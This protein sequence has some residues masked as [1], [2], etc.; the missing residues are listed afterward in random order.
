MLPAG[1]RDPA[2]RGVQRGGGGT[3]PERDVV[4]GEPTLGL[5]RQ[6]VL[7]ALAQQEVLGQRRTLVGQVRLGG[8][9]RHGAF[10]AGVAEGAGRGQPGRPAADDDHSGAP[11]SRAF[12]HVEPVVRAVLAAQRM[13]VDAGRQRAVHLPALERILARL[14]GP[15]HC[16][17]HAAGGERPRSRCPGRARAARAPSSRGP[18]S[19][20]S[21]RSCRPASPRA[22][23]HAGRARARGRA[24]AHGRRSTAAGAMSTATSSRH[25][26]ASSAVNT[27]IEQPTSSPRSNCHGAQRPQRMCRTCPARTGWWR[28]PTDP[29]RGRTDRRSSRARGGPPARGSCVQ[30]PAPE[31]DQQWVQPVLVEEQLEVAAGSVQAAAGG[32][33]TRSEPAPPGGWWSVPRRPRRPAAPPTGPWS[34]R[35]DLPRWRRRRARTTRSIVPAAAVIRP[36][37]RARGRR[38]PA[39]VPAWPRL[40]PHGVHQS[41]PAGGGADGVPAEVRLAGD[42]AGS[43]YHR[44]HGR[45]AEYHAVALG[46]AHARRA[47]P[48]VVHLRALGHV[49]IG[50][51]RRPGLSPLTSTNAA[52]TPPAPEQKVLT[53]LTRLHQARRLPSPVP[54]SAPQ[55]PSS[56][57]VVAH[58]RTRARAATRGGLA[59]ALDGV[60]VAV[61]DAGHRAIGA[62]HGADDSPLLTRRRPGRG[63]AGGPEAAKASVGERGQRSSCA[64]LAA[65]PPW[66]PPRSAGESNARC[67]TAPPATRATPRVGPSRPAADSVAPTVWAQSGAPRTRAEPVVHQ[68]H[69]ALPDGRGAGGEHAAACRHAS[70]VF[71]RPSARSSRSRRSASSLVWSVITP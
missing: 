61:Q 2:G 16:Q 39:A 50:Q 27:P 54:G 52:S 51:Q 7:T 21:G 64:A 42:L 70:R 68:H 71:R 29:H 69:A 53:P 6:F 66:P 28:T 41:R 43:A 19:T 45:A 37:A 33:W 1:Q 67:S 26:G 3:G 23:T 15:V 18:P 60:E 38:W 11:R 56:S 59:E 30:D 35:R 46:G 49:H 22:A 55:T 13:E 36:A 10:A 48:G 44:E 40:L 32:Q 20:R 65:R 12:E 17:Q 9:D 34:A 24:C 31:L 62:R 63:Q 57:P 58:A 5:D 4:L 47:V 25:R 14:L 8:Q